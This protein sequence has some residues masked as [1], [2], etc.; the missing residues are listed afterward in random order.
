MSVR[1]FGLAR[2]AARLKRRIAESVFKTAAFNPSATPP[3]RNFALSVQA[4]TTL[5]QIYPGGWGR[6]KA[7]RQKGGGNNCRGIKKP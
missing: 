1:F 6:V 4:A 7:K 2:C 5:L 3:R